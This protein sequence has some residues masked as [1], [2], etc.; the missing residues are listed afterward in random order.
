[1]KRKLPIALL[2]SVAS[3]LLSGGNAGAVSDGLMAANVVP[4]GESGATTMA[5]FAAATA[6]LSSSYGPNTDNQEPLYADWQ[7]KPMQFQ[8]DPAHP[9]SAPPGDSNVLIWRDPSYGVPTITG[10]TD[11]DTFYGLGYAM[12]QDRLFQMEVF[13]HVGHGTLASLIGPSGLPIDEAVRRYTEGQAALQAEFDALPADAQQRGSMFI[14]GINAYIKQLGANPLELPAEFT[15]LGDMPVKPWTIG[16]LLGFGEYAGRFFGEF[17]HGELAAEQLYVDLLN[18]FGTRKAETILGDV[19]PLNDQRAPSSISAADGTFP[20]HVANPVPT[21]FRKSVYA[22]HAPQYLA[23][24]TQI[25]QLAGSVD[26]RQSLVSRLTRKLG[27]PRFGSNAVTVSGKLTAD[28]KPMVYGGPQT[29]WS[30]P[31]YFWEA[32]L[33]SPV[34]D[35]RGVF[36]PAL[37]VMVIGRNAT[38]A[39][40]VTSAL[41][42]NSDTFV[43]QLN[44]TNTTYTHNGQTLIVQKQ[45]ETIPCKNPPSGATSLLSAV[46]PKLC[47]STPTTITVY[48]TIHGPSIADP[49]AAHQLFVR[50]SAVDNHL[51][52]SLEAWDLAGRQTTAKAFGSALAGLSL[53]FNFLYADDH[54]QIGYWHV[55]R[56]PVRAANADSRLPLPGTGA[57]DWKRFESW[58]AHPHVIDPKSGFI[59]NWNNKPA[60]NWWSKAIGTGGE[61]GLWGDQNQ[62]TTLQRDVRAKAPLSFQTLGQVPRDVAYTDNRARILLPYLLRAMQHTTNPQLVTIRGYLEQWNEERNLITAT[63][64]YATPAIVFF[65]RFVEM[66]MRDVEQPVLGGNWVQLGGLSCATCQLVSVDNLS[67]PTYKFEYPGLQLLASALAGHTKFHFISNRMSVLLQ[68]AADASAELTNTQGSDPAKWNEPVEQTTFSAQGA[69]SAPPITPLMNRG[70]YGQVV[71]A[72]GAP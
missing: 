56:Y 25:G 4:P 14:A 68:A 46:L 65:D 20:R 70:S 36:V 21:R 43:E 1:M 18:R 16:D 10:K 30:V 51:L 19:I 6:G 45:V 2:L 60:I 31:G 67:A 47:P 9:G 57:Y 3:L 13:R 54:G 37:P 27:L 24:Q 59:A 49:D 26:R 52:Q 32:E 69:I 23:T 17:G 41:D 8:S 35:Q 38:A 48:R 5:Q 66:L 7:Y 33:H 42:A 39:W 61:G 58:G 62:V 15:L 12:A 72:T 22:N 29:G 55:G 28:H 40:T 11:A 64:T 53:G 50:Q 34:R 71:E 63:G 44:A